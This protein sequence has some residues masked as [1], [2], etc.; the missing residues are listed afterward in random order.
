VPAPAP[1]APDAR[2]KAD[3]RGHDN[4]AAPRAPSEQHGRLEERA[5]TPQRTQPPPP[6]KAEPRPPA[7]AESANQ[8]HGKKADDA[9]EK[10]QHKK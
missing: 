1:Q 7:K 5:P 8:S 4:K 6:T 9:E 10:G 3:D 2:G